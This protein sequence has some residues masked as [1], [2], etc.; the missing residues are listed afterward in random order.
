MVVAEEEIVE[1]QFIKINVRHITD[2]KGVVFGSLL[3]T[4]KTAMFN[5]NLTD[6]LVMETD[7][8]DGYQIVAP[9]E[10]VVNYA[11]FNDFY[12]FNSSFGID[13]REEDKGTLYMPKGDG[14][15]EGAGRRFS[16]KFFVSSFG[17]KNR[18]RFRFDSE[19]C[20]N[21]P[22]MSFFLV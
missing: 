9:S 3:V 10:L 11:I 19:T 18:L 17:L 4:P 21:Y 20:L 2:G 7:Q 8:P 22:F 14:D 15:K 1:R 13:V 5:P 12:K 6:L 16:R